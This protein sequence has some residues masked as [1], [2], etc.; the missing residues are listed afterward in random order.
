MDDEI[1]RKRAER[2]E[3][4]AA[5]AARP[6]ARPPPLELD[7]AIV[8]REWASVYHGASDALPARRVRIVSW[9]MLAQ[10][11]VRRDLFPG[12]DCLKFR[13]RL[14][15]IIA[16]L[17]AHDWDL[18]CFQEVDS[19]DEIGPRLRQAGYAFQYE[20][21]YDTKR[22]GLLVAWRSQPGTRVSFGEPMLSKV[23]R[24]DDAAPW[25]EHANG[26]SLSR[27]TRNIALILAL[28]FAEGDGGI[29]I[30]TTH[31][32]WHPRYEYERVRQAA[33]IVQELNQVRAS[34][35]PWQHWPAV[36]AGDLNDQPHSS[37]YTMLTTP[38]DAYV[39]SLEADL[40]PSMVVH[41][42]VDEARHLRTVH[43]ASTVTEGG[44]EDRVLGRH[45]QPMERELVL[46][47]RLCE[48]AHIASAPSRPTC[49][50]STYAAK[51]GEVDAKYNPEYFK[52]RCHLTSESWHGTGA[53]R[54]DIA[55][56][57]YRPAAADEQ[58]A[59]VDALLVAFSSDAGLH[60]AG[61]PTT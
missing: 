48:F 19:M 45:R 10:S 60:Y 35:A 11:L 52:V 47:A 23:V 54:P 25:G 39:P 50:Q 36:L 38:G 8:A 13:T 17:T 57:A 26:E 46:P 21:G 33:I 1:A 42:S 24:L 31:L 16:E 61:A 12:S 29:L 53:L 15:G 51:Y 27:I 32:F 20:K 30:V 59:Q 41:T 9:N 58:R 18:G 56:G 22:H 3:R 43:Y 49:F 37:T 2:A 4:K 44:D 14:P 6:P 34:D 28:P 7:G 5:A 55:A 40:A